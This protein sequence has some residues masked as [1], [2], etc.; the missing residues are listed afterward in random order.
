ML[1][2]VINKQTKNSFG[3]ESVVAHLFFCVWFCLICFVLLLS[4]ALFICFLVFFVFVL[5]FV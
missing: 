5:L 3:L 2:D 1:N 4:F